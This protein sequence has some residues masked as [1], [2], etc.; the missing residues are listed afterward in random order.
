[1]TEDPKSLL[2][3]I[4]RL[5]DGLG[6]PCVVGGSL[7]STA[8]G[9]PRTTL[10]ADIVIEL[11]AHQIEPLATRLEA[12]FYVSRE[13]MREAVRTHGSFNAIHLLSVVKVDFFVLGTSPFDRSEFERR[14]PQTLLPDEGGRV[15]LKTPEDILLRKLHW[16][17]TGGEVSEQQWRD[18]LGVLQVQ[19]G[20]L[21]EV[22]LDHWAEQL[23]VTDLL[24]RARQDSV[25]G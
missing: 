16:Y 11:G 22:Y 15:M 24:A 17:R 14:V 6:I 13:A 21:D 3:A 7:A 9:R 4:A 12:E 19:S 25:I 8:Y 20:R 10:D 1:M 18:V 23:G 5:L 2:I